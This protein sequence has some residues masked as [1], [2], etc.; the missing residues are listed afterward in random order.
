[1]KLCY[2]G[3]LYQLE[4]SPMP[5]SETEIIGKYRSQIWQKNKF[6]TTLKPLSSIPYLLKFRGRVYEKARFKLVDPQVQMKEAV[7]L[8]SLLGE[9]SSP[10][11]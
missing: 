8:D 3:V 9:V 7:T 10:I 11:N 5:V 4:T 2:R 6:A 1:M